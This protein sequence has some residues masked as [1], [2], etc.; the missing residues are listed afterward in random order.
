VAGAGALMYATSPVGQLAA[1]PNARFG[2]NVR[3][4]SWEF[5]LSAQREVTRGIQVNGGYFRRW[6]GNFLVTDDLNH[7]A[8]D[9]APFTITPGLIPPPPVSAGGLP[10]PASVLTGTFYALKQGT[11][12]AA[13]APFVGLSDQMFPGSNVTDHWNGFDFGVSMRLPH[14]VV[15]QGGTSTGRQT[16]N[17]CDIVDPANAGKFGSRSPLV[18]LLTSSLGVISPVSTCAVQQAWLTQIK[19]LGSFTIPKIEVRIGAAF[20][21]IPGLEEA[22]TYSTPNSDIARPV[23]QGGLGA[24]PLGA[25]SATA[26]TNL[27]LL[28]PQNDYYTRLNQLD[29]RLGKLL[30]FG[31]TRANLSLDF[32][33]LL[34]QDTVTS[35]SFAYNTSWL[36]PSAVIAPRLMKVSL[37]FDF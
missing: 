3:P 14:G 7:S 12:V 35:A 25:V 34:N 24:L 31:Q 10:L 18:E 32:Y 26:T 11:A 13:A 27:A 5:S 8:T 15:F 30:R 2:W 16:T 21:S 20:Q 1:D 37:T 36:A 9:Y 28:P 33:N 22:L 19:F 6:F 23:A 29:L 17:D 4:Y